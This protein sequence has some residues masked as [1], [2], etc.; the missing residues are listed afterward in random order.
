MDSKILSDIKNKL[1]EEL[2][3]AEDR[4]L[5]INKQDPFVDT[6]RLNDNAASDTEAAEEAD[7]DRVAAVKSEVLANIERIKKALAKISDGVYGKC[8]KC[9]LMI[10]E[11]RLEVFPEASFCFECER[12]RE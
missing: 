6:S 10:D 7:H 5:E 9:G 3:I 11:K 2:K 4:L 12:K 8:E 1:D